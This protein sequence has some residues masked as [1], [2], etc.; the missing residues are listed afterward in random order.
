[1]SALNYPLHCT[2][3]STAVFR[4]TQLLPYLPREPFTKPPLLQESSLTGGGSPNLLDLVEWKSPESGKWEL[5]IFSIYF[6]HD[7][8]LVFYSQLI[9]TCSVLLLL[10][11]S[12]VL[13]FP[14]YKNTGDGR[15]ATHQLYSFAI[16]VVVGTDANSTSQ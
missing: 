1:M 12:T 10:P 7:C 9:Q 16:E 2:E 4:V 15:A 13:G 5:Q 11:F 3:F 8:T 14:L 6:T